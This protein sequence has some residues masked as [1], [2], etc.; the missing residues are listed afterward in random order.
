MTKEQREKH[1]IE[2]VSKLHKILT[3]F[4]LRR[5]KKDVLKELPPKK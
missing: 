4:M 1:N 5:T 3:P 2:M